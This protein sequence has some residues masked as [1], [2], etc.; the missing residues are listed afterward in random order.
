MISEFSSHAGSPLTRAKTRATDLYFVPSPG[1]PAVNVELIV[2]RALGLIAP[3]IAIAAA[4]F[5]RYC[6]AWM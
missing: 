4:L 1:R 5:D 6:C 2:V 3:L